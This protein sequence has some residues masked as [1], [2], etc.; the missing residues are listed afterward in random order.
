M[1][2]R[3][4]WGRAGAIITQWLA[5]VTTGPMG[6]YSLLHSASRL[7]TTCALVGFTGVSTSNFIEDL[8]LNWRDT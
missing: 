8:E 3:D 6:V 4:Q 7:E 1:R 5:D 2:E